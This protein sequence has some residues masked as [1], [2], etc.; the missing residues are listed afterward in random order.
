MT[1]LSSGRPS[2]NAQMLKMMEDDKDLMIKT[3]FNFTRRFH[4]EAREFALKH[5]MTLKELIH[6]ALQQYIRE[7]GNKVIQK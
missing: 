7:Y 4:K 3:T 1:V 5:D 2:T 6:I